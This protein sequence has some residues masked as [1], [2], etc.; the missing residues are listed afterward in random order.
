MRLGQPN[1]GVSLDAAS[2]QLSHQGQIIEPPLS[3][4]E[5]TDRDDRACLSAVKEMSTVLSVWSDLQS[6]L[7]PLL[8]NCEKLT[9]KCKGTN[10]LELLHQRVH[11]DFDLQQYSTSP[12]FV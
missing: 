6:L 8:L 5:N 2:Y 9:N 3:C 12:S 10:H 4:L 11:L 1:L 7:L